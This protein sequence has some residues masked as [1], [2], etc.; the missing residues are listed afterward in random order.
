MQYGR[1]CESNSGCY[2]YL[3]FE[4]KVVKRFVQCRLVAQSP[5]GRHSNDKYPVNTLH[6]SRFV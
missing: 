4:K 5:P 1:K 6:H 3:L 2:Y